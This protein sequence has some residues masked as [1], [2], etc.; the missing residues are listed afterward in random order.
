[1]ENDELIIEIQH[2]NQTSLP[3]SKVL[4]S[5]VLPSLPKITLDPLVP[6]QMDPTSSY[7]FV[8]QFVCETKNRSF[9]IHVISDLILF[10][11]FFSYIHNQFSIT[12]KMIQSAR[13]RLEEIKLE[14]GL[15]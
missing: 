3:S 5:N 11:L 6:T 4:P 12:E 9:L 13:E 2:D 8:Y 15:D 1:M 14:H 7:Q 10:Y